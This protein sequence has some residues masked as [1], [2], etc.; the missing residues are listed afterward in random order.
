MADIAGCRSATNIQ[1][2]ILHSLDRI[3]VVAQIADNK[4]N[5]QFFRD[6]ILKFSATFAR[7]FPQLLLNRGR[8]SEYNT[9]K[10]VHAD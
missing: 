5:A 7:I 8:Y 9:T 6:F 1:L 4:L 3:I 10:C 2:T